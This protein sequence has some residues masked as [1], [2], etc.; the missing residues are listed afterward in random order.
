MIKYLIPFLILGSVFVKADTLPMKPH[1]IPEEYKI[2]PVTNKEENEEMIRIS[3]TDSEFHIVIDSLKIAADSIQK[4]DPQ[5]ASKLRGLHQ[6]L[7][8]H[9]DLNLEE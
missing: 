3:L 5:Y 6:E 8:P 7:L 1:I 2:K 9:F 4:S